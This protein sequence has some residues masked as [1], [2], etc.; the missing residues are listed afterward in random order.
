MRVRKSNFFTIVRI[1]GLFFVG[2]VVAVSIALS[3]V[4]LE[5]LRGNIV[6]ILRD[7]TG[8]PVE[9]DGS[10]SW[11]LSLRPQVELNKVYIPNPEWA[12][13]K[14]AFSADKI[15]V[16]VN[17][18]SLFRAR[19]TIQNVKVY[20]AVVNIEQNSDGVYSSQSLFDKLTDKNPTKTE[21]AKYAFKD[22]GLGGLEIKGLNFNVLG[23]S[24]N[25]TGLNIRYFSKQD[26]PE[27]SG[28]IKSGDDVIPYIVSLSE[29][30]AE[31]KIYPVRVA[32]A[33][34]GDNA[35]I[36]NV[37]L[38]GTSKAPIDFVIKG[39]LPNAAAVGKIFGMDW[40]AFPRA[41]VNMAG[42]LDRKKIT[43]RK[44]SIAL[45]GTEFDVSGTYD[46][47]KAVPIINVKLGSQDVSLL[48]LFPDLYKHNG[49]PINR[50][51]NVFKDVPLFGEFF[52]DKSI[53]LNVALDNFVVYRGLS[54]QQ[55]NL[56][57]KVNDNRARIDLKSGF[58][59]GNLEIGIDAD[60]APEGSLDLQVGGIGERLYVG[61]ILKQL[62]Y[63]NLLSELPVNF[64]L[65][66]QAKGKDLSQV[67]NTITGPVYVYSVA[68]G[69]AHSTLVANM[70]GTDFLTS[71][72]HSIQ[73]L[74]RSEKKYN[75]MKISCLAVNVKLRDGLVETQNGV[76]LET[77]AINVRLAGD[78]DLGDE[79]MHLSLMTVPVRG[80][81]LSLTGKVV[82][83]IELT[84]NLAEPDIK[85]SGAAM[86]GKVASATGIGLLLAPLTGGIGL[87]AGAGIGLV[88]GDL[89]ENWLADDHPCKTAMKRGAPVRR[90][91]PEW[92]G[93][94]MA[95]LVG[96]VLHPQTESNL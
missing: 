83:S 89:L 40:S 43:L 18:I 29:Y 16:K 59:D 48:K 36:A 67:M 68:P 96:P 87:V 80:L 44:S 57:A 15:D 58:A 20:D 93:M 51:L 55:M 76:A 11:K 72:R 73:D 39:D 1:I 75:Q 94:P 74:F 33:T 79:K 3:Q 37:A 21:P 10:V 6:A 31:R 23:T 70:Y 54:F 85:I 4:N 92:L 91:D 13:N 90:D 47:G 53:D 52:R 19:P 71:L 24:L 5:T 63:S 61:E 56:H 32:M 38:E 45:R 27:Y 22:L 82:N 46:W 95:D 50:E 41:A 62:N 34:G 86:A 69:Y 88:A 12:K 77:N 78:L 9:I 30:N 64:E 60:I 35:L 28:W 25:V 17:L 8:M 2:L 7:A 14:N 81:K 49:G 26:G 42:G 66:V 65:Y 84:G